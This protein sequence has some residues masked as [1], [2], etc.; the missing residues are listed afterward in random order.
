[1]FILKMEAEFFS[2]FVRYISR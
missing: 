1:M 2:M